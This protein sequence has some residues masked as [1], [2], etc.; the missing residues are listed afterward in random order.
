MHLRQCTTSLQSLFCTHCRQ[1]SCLH[2][3]IIYLADLCIAWHGS[4]E[5]LNKY[6]VVHASS[7]ANIWL[8]DAFVMQLRLNG[9]GEEE[10]NSHR[11]IRDQ[12]G[13]FDDDSPKFA[14]A[15]SAD[16]LSGGCGHPDFYQPI[17]MS[18][19][20]Q[21]VLWHTGRH[22]LPSGERGRS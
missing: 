7:S 8:I 20:C 4:I 17:L 16:F 13:C 18:K 6:F 9:Q 12:S 10:V 14:A 5:F 2:M 19:C 15:A 21:R 1:V 3:I 22:M 11:S